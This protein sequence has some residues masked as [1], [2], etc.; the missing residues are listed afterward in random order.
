MGYYDLSPTMKNYYSKWGYNNIYDDK[1]DKV[2]NATSINPISSWKKEYSLPFMPVGW[3]R[4]I[5]QYLKESKTNPNK[6]K[7]F[8]K[9]LRMTQPVLK[10][11]LKSKLENLGYDTRFHEG[12]VYGKGEIPVLLVAHM[13]T[14]H[15]EIPYQIIY[16][17]DYMFSPQGIGG[18]DRCGV[19]MILQIIEELKC[20]VLF[21]ED[22]EIGCVGADMFTVSSYPELLKGKLNYIIEFDRRNSNDCVF[23][24]CDN[25]DF[26]NFIIKSSGNHFKTAWGSCSDISYIAPVL[27]VAA[28]NLSCGYYQEHTLEHYINVKEMNINIEK[29]KQ[30]IKT[31]CEEPFKYISVYNYRNTYNNYGYGYYDYGYDDYDYD[32][33]GYSKQKPKAKSYH[34]YD[35]TSDNPVKFDNEIYTP[36]ECNNPMIFHIYYETH[37]EWSEKAVEILA[38]NEDE[39]VGLFLKANPDLCYGDIIDI[40]S[41]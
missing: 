15:K 11:Y 31:P 27:K 30:I 6:N 17:D 36:H 22:E 2:T 1:K 10:N 18:D 24:D 16:K 9:I 7:K 33:Y 3:K 40:I 41:M 12:F 26:D 5:D 39:A 38:S 28:V 23:Y 21:T 35:V 25:P 8:E 32:Y 34:S 19:W 4:N 14:V 20:H 29:A 13:D 37:F